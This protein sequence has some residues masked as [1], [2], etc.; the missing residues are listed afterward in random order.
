L[1]PKKQVKTAELVRLPAEVNA[2]NRL[3]VFHVWRKTAAALGAVDL[4]LDM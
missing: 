1:I 3:Q 2:E 4:V